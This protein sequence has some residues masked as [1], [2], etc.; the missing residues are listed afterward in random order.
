MAHRPPPRCGSVAD[1]NATPFAMILM[2]KRPDVAAL[3]Q[4]PGGGWRAYLRPEPPP[5]LQF[6]SH[7]EE[8]GGVFGQ[9][10][11]LNGNFL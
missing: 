8:G 2:G 4:N 9:E 10:L 5:N 11:P 3:R 7:M 1:E 6:A